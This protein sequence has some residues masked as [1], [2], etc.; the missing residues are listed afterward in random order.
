MGAV[1]KPIKE[2]K[3]QEAEWEAE[4][5]KWSAD[6]GGHGQKR[7]PS[8]SKDFDPEQMMKTEPEHRSRLP[9]PYIGKLFYVLSIY[10][11]SIY[12]SMTVRTTFSAKTPLIYLEEVL[13]S[14]H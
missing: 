13:V 7:S 12:L 10:L 4:G 2:E 14:P 11:E 1:E 9:S 6:V 5:E 8:P 3:E